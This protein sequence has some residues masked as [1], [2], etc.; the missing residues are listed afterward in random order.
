MITGGRPRSP[1]TRPI[2]V[3]TMPRD[4]GEVTVLADGKDGAWY[5]TGD[6]VVPDGRGGL[7]MAA[8]AADR[9]GGPS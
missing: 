4:G 7:R 2:C 6:L 3:A 1:A 5:D 9:V 8:R